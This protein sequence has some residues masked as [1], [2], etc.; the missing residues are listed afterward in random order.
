LIYVVIVPFRACLHRAGQSRDSCLASRYDLRS[1]ARQAV[2]T[3]RSVSGS[4]V[5]PSVVLF[6]ILPCFYC[7]Q[8][9]TI[10]RMSW[11]TSPP[12]SLKAVSRQP[13]ESTAATTP[14]PVLS[15]KSVPRSFALQ[16]NNTAINTKAKTRTPVDPHKL[17]KLANALG[18][19]TPSPGSVP[20]P[21]YSPSTPNSA[22]FGASA[23]TPSRYLLHVIPPLHLLL[24]EQEDASNDPRAQAQFRR[25]TLVP[26]HPTLTS[27]L[28]AI[29]R[30]FSLPS[31]G[32]MILYLITTDNDPGPRIT[33]D[34]WRMLCEEKVKWRDDVKE[35]A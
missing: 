19:S 16:N 24:A 27:Q 2:T 5:I 8:L 11:T 25:G 13:T 3:D 7:Y 15:P 12:Y 6:L 32:G 30:E 26:L 22:S 33:D 18:V 10:P 23:S 35:V 20:Y 17:A 29:A 31:T 34:A 4:R 21:L 1:L 28:G 14:P 9:L